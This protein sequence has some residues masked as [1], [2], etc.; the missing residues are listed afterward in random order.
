MGENE[1]YL[2][3][4]KMFQKRQQKKED[5]KEIRGYSR[6]KPYSRP[7]SF[8]FQPAAAAGSSTQAATSA[9]YRSTSFGGGSFSRQ[10]AS[11]YQQG[12]RFPDRSRVRCHNCGEF[13]HYANECPKLGSNR[14]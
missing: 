3:V 12:R 7:K 4:A 13:G 6:P 1:N 9:S 8:G 2:K 11:G 14:M 10:N 5:E